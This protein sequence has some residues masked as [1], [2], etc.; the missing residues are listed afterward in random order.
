MTD[1]NTDPVAFGICRG[2]VDDPTLSGFPEVWQYSPDQANGC[3]CVDCPE[4]AEVRLGV[5][6]EVNHLQDADV[7]GQGVQ[8]SDTINRAVDPRGG[9]GR[10]GR[11]EGKR[12][13]GVGPGSEGIRLSHVP[14][15][16][17]EGP[18]ILKE[19]SRDR[20]AGPSRSA[21]SSAR[22]SPVH[23]D[24]TRPVARAAESRSKLAERA[25]TSI[26]MSARNGA[27]TAVM[28]PDRP[29][30]VLSMAVFLQAAPVRAAAATIAP[31]EAGVRSIIRRSFA[32]SPFSWP[33]F[34]IA[35]TMPLTGPS[36][37][38]TC[39]G[40]NP[41]AAG[42]AAALSPSGGKGGMVASLERQLAA[43][44][45]PCSHF[46]LLFDNVRLRWVAQQDFETGKLSGIQDCDLPEECCIS[47][48]Q[49]CRG[50][51]GR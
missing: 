14:Q 24:A 39:P 19:L 18:A 22:N 13:Q 6:L 48:D 51:D 37:N 28:G 26:D 7:V 30:A 8:L 12:R 42:P 50:P 40:R 3:L 16:Q 15:T 49:H 34:W 21:R 36:P 1:G 17:R 41:W 27:S 43:L 11:I 47:R 35:W 46:E 29:I 20:R 25:S 5:L 44:R 33:V 45:Q 31:G 32:N 10:V 38:F 4:V 2:D 9:R 23:P